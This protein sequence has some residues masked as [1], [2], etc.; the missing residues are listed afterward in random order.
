VDL[1]WTNPTRTTDG[2]SLIAKH[3]AGALTAEICR[4]ETFST[5]T[6]API[7]KMLVASGAPATFHDVLPADLQTGPARALHYRVRVLNADGQGAAFTEVLAAAGEAPAA[8]RGLQ[9]SP[10]AGGISVR[11][12]PG[13]GPQ[14]RTLLRVTRGAAP[15]TGSTTAAK[16]Q[17]P[18][19]LAVEAAAQDAGGAI[20]TGG[21]AGVE[22]S[23]A[24]YRA[25]T[26][27][28]GDAEL[29]LKGEPANVT[30]PADAKAPLPVPPTGLEAIAN[31][32][33]SPE[34]DLVWQAGSEPGVA[35]YL[36]FRSE[37][38][39]PPRQLTMTPIQSFSYADTTARPGVTYRYSVAAVGADGRAGRAGEELLALI[40]VP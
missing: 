29:L 30:V 3:G 2:V 39:G 15:A 13:A 22:Q 25:R 9:A 27:K 8:M 17:A 23:Y 21:R 18:V 19:L 7:T 26:V 1:A 5:A 12:Q 37:A 28:I 33:A 20:D 10:I 14:D 16:P 24:V 40:P 32:L 6:C 4:A 11:W 38:G 36:V 34:I 31:T 35:G